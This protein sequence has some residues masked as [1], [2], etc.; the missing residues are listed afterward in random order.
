MKKAGMVKI[1]YYH[2]TKK[3]LLEK[4]AHFCSLLT[5]GGVASE[6]PGLLHALDNAEIW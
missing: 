1:S 2:V 5:P 3:V 6:Q 4:A